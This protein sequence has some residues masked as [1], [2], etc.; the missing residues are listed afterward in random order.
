MKIQCNPN[1]GRASDEELLED[2]RRVA[3]ELGGTH[4]PAAEY[5]K[6]G[7]F[8]QMTLRRR[9][10]GWHNALEAAGLPRPTNLFKIPVES[11]ME[12]LKEVILKVKRTPSAREMKMPL[13]RYNF[14]TYILRFGRWSTALAYFA[15]YCKKKGDHTIEF[16]NKRPAR[17]KPRHATRRTPLKWMRNEVL[18]RDGFR[19]CNCGKS[20]EVD[21]K[22]ILEVDH[23]TPW[24]RGGETVLENLQTLCRPCHILKRKAEQEWNNS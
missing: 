13:S 17:R 20:P 5:E 11:L 4:F 14:S 10:G 16:S 15:D 18:M 21:P 3:R 23:K 19:C 9:F 12:N 8:S 22:H 2:V 1:S 7:R 6:R 24:S